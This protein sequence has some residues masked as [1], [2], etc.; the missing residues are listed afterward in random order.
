MKVF[1]FLRIIGLVFAMLLTSTLCAEVMPVQGDRAK[2]VKKELPAKVTVQIVSATIGPSKFGG[3]K[4]HGFGQVEQGLIN[5][6]AV[7]LAAETGG[8]SL[9]LSA[10]STPALQNSAPDPWGWVEV[11]IDGEFMPPLKHAFYANSKEIIRKT[12][13]PS[14][15]NCEY[16]NVPLNE[17][18]RFKVNLWNNH[19]IL[20]KDEP[21]GVAEINMKDLVTALE[22]QK[23]YQVQVADQTQN[24]LLFLGIEVRA[25]KE[26]TPELARGI[27]LNSL[28]KALNVV[29]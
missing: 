21:I 29:K 12:F 17:G 14:F 6:I 8:F 3:G 26:Q 7:G 18:T 9:V 25:S 10:L 11:A 13:T 16:T 2:E 24:Q 20:G 1:N 4:W 22:A 27:D 5:K 15:Q 23:I 28:L 19:S